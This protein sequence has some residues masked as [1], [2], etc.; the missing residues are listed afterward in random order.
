MSHQTGIKPSTDL[1]EQFKAASDGSIRAIKV[2]IEDETL[3][4]VASL[5][6]EADGSWESGFGKLEGWLDPKQACYILYRLDT[7]TSA[8]EFGWVLLQYV[9]DH[10]KVRD[11]ML[12]AATKA[13]LL[14]ILG[15]SKFV[16]F[17]HT[18]NQSEVTLEGYKK[19]LEHKE[20]DAPLTEKERENERVKQTEVGADIGASTRRSN[21]SGIGLPVSDEAQKGLAEFRDGAIKI[22]VFTIDTTSESIGLLASK[23]DGK[24]E[25]VRGIVQ[26]SQPAF[27]LYRYEDKVAFVYICPPSSKV[28]SRMV[29]S[30]AKGAFIQFLQ[31]DF[32][33]VPDSRTELDT[34]Q[35]VDETYLRDQ[36]GFTVKAAPTT[37]LAFAKPARPGRG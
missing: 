3:I 29:Y 22:A 7:K 13:T 33:I 23:S 14:K 12:Y 5:E 17:V 21:V 18:T 10:A 28:K 4:P 1:I 16:D 32:N 11:K 31:T 25:D 2:Q 36:L 20:A 15:D 30:S 24:P 9:P 8:D 19:H 35:E 6:E 34:A 26:D 37:R 27:L